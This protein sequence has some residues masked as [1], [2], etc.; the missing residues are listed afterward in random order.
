[1]A[2]IGF[3]NAGLLALGPALWVLFGANVGTTMTGWIV[4]LVGLKFKVEAL[5]MPLA[6]LGALLRL[7]GEGRRS[8]AIGTALAGFGLLFMGIALLQQAFA[9]LAGQISLPQGHG[10]A[11]RAGATRHRHADD[12]A[13]AVVQRGH[14]HH[15]HRR[16]GRADRPAGRGGGGHRRQRRHHGDGRA[17]RHRRHAERTPGRGGARGLQPADRARSR[18]CCCP[19]SSA[20][21]LAREALDLPPDP[22]T[23][24]ALFHTTFNLLGVLLMWPLA[25]P[26]HTLAAAALSG[27]RGGRGAAQ[28]L[29][30][31]VLAVPTLAL[32]ALTREVAAPGRWRCA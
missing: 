3:V 17:G 1:V 31:T 8:G 12:G 10:R 11:V 27:A 14:G 16:A 4:A 22:A 7:T 29:D 5:A 19:G 28:F 2:A 6:G 15:A 32:D 20:L 23:K 13:D 26:A 25:A 18:C 9:G 21:G 30:D 24:L